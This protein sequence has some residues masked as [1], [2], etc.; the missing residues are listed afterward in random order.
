MGEDDFYI[1]FSRGSLLILIILFIILLV[2]FVRAIYLI[3][4]L[5]KKKKENE[6]KL[7]ELNI[8]VITLEGKIR[9][10]E[11]LVEKINSE[12]KN[13]ATEIASGQFDEWKKKELEQHRK[14][15]IETAIERAKAL[16]H[17][18][19]I[20][21]EK[22]LRKD[23]VTRSMG[24]NYG[25]ITE[26]LIPFS[27]HLEEFDPRDVRFI[28]SP[29]DLMIF[30]GA[31]SKKNSIDV[32]LVEIKTGSG[33]LSKRQKAIKNAIEENRVYWK[34][35]IVPEFKWD[36]DLEDDYNSEIIETK[37]TIGKIIV[38]DDHSMF[39]K[40]LISALSKYQ[41]I[42]VIGE[43]ENGK[44]LLDKL[45]YLSPDVILLDIQMPIMDGITSLQIIKQ[46][47]PK[48]KV[49]IFSF[50]TDPKVIKRCME[51]GASS[52][53]TAEKGIDFIYKTIFE[54]LRNEIYYNEL[55]ISA[56]NDIG[57]SE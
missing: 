26:H 56:L 52:Y 2:L 28:G 6:K 12:L 16:L 8:N 31:T 25:K 15:I 41:D 5:S 19:Q 18:W 37:P 14:I 32:Y 17:E 30:D 45:E 24:V 57:K 51:L 49:I 40:G 23:A 9:E 13:Q 34:Q 10:K 36:I 29:V 50:L 55:V 48:I 11:L 3:S 38:T 35:I 44:D 4:N 47:F 20:E 7:N 43:A 46:K 42:E 27:R 39:R 1:S 53:I 33:Q 21:K 54:C 22:E